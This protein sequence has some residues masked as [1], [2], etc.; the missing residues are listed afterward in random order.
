MIATP[1]PTRRPGE[2]QPRASV[3]FSHRL[4]RRRAA[5]DQQLAAG[6]DP[7]TSDALERRAAQLTAVKYRAAVATG[8][9]RVIEAAEEPPYA[10][11]SPDRLRRAEILASQGVLLSL[12]RELRSE[13][14]VRVR[15]VALARRLLTDSRGPLYTA[16]TSDEVECVARA[17]R[18]AL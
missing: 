13:R 10:L 6:V 15:G 12:A 8:F 17:A 18:D 4:W 3:G 14:P 11:S 5:L 7:S 16:T 2:D 1:V 9:E